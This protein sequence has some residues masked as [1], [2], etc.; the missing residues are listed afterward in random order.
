LTWQEGE[1]WEFRLEMRGS[2]ESDQYEIGGVL[3]RGEE[4]M[5]LTAEGVDLHVAGARPDLVPA[6]G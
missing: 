6:A 2:R 1:P 5:D 4:R 3:W